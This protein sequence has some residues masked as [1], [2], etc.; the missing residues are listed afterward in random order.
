MNPVWKIFTSL[1]L[2]VTL[3][4][5]S[6]LLIFFG[7]LAQVDEGLW[8]AQEIWFRSFL[9][10]GQKLRLF[11]WHFT[12]PI[13]PGGYLI[14]FTLLTNLTCAFLKR[15]Q[16]RRDKI[17]IHLIHSGVILLLLG[18]LLTDLLSNESHLRLREGE[19]KNYSEAHRRNELIF[20]TDA[21]PPNEEIVAI[22]ESLLKPGA[23]IQHEKLPFIVR[24]KEYGL[25]SDLRRRGPAVDGPSPATQGVGQQLVVEAQ[26]E[27][28]D[29]DSR[30]VPYAYIEL[31]KGGQSLGT[32]LVTPGLGMR[33]VP[34]QEIIVDGRTLRTD[35]RSERYYKPFA[36]TLLKTTHEIY[37]GT[38]IPKNFRSRVRIENPVRSENREIDI[39]MN[40]PLRYEGLTFFQYQMGRDEIDQG[41]DVPFS[42]LQVVKNPGWLAPYAGCYVVALGMYVQFR[43]HLTHFLR[44]RLASGGASRARFGRAGPIAG[45]LLEVG[46]LGYLVLRFTLKLFGY[47]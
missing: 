38:D 37:R 31:V 8:K 45:R 44:K 2:T 47:A 1:R 43:H 35:F 24:V 30:N 14:G 3:L 29:M 19:T 6:L 12:V 9:V 17:G 22:P 28:K 26:P 34:P 11:N 23:T 39:Y 18:Q 7:T 41:R 4:A 40:N 42:I 5:L 32:W 46:L 36:V 25:N 10:V 33:G 20:A 13:F 15:F 16:W 21:Q 27:T